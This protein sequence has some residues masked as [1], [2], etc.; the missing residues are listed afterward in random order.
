MKPPAKKIEMSARVVFSNQ[1]NTKHV[2]IMANPN[3]L[4]FQFLKIL[5]NINY[6]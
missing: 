1:R 4:V 2:R 6:P 5:S 3:V